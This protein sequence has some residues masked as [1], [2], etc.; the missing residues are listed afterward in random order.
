M[1]LFDEEGAEIAR[2][3]TDEQGAYDFCDIQPGDYEVEP[4]T[5]C[6]EPPVGFVQVV[7]GEQIPQVDLSLVPPT[8]IVGY[9][10][11]DLDGDGWRAV[12]EPPLAGVPVTVQDPSG[13]EVTL[14]TDEHGRY[15]LCGLPGHVIVTVSVD[16]DAVW[17]TPTEGRARVGCPSPGFGHISP[18]QDIP[19][20][21]TLALLGSGLAALAGLA[22]RSRRC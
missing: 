8:C 17:T 1:I 6:V 13:H 18:P 2:T 12:G 10:W 14:V 21:S 3:V 11:E 16:G 22:R 19:E 9:V 20:P 7:P 15:E 5:P 4:D